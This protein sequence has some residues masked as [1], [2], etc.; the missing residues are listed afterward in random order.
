MTVAAD[1]L[2]KK[3]NSRMSC[4]LAQCEDLVETLLHR[5]PQ[6]LQVFED[7]TIGV[8]GDTTHAAMRAHRRGQ[9]GA[10]KGAKTNIRSKRAP[11]M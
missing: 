8:H 6:Q 9:N 5:A 11:A 4:C 1:C 2:E 3:G 10:G 7:L